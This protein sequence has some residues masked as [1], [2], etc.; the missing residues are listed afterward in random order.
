MEFEIKGT[1]AGSTPSVRSTSAIYGAVAPAAVASQPAGEWN[2][3]EVT[4]VG[5]RLKTVWNGR[6]VH[7][8]NLDDPAYAA[9]QRGPLSG[10]ATLGHIGF[11]AHL[12]GSPVEFRHVRLKV[13]PTAP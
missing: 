8:I 7:D 2:Q 1:D 9:A 5:R 12:T 11:Q 10:R 13:L 3:V 6:V 4:V